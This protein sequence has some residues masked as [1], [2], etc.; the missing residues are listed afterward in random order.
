MMNDQNTYAIIGMFAIVITLYAMRD[1]H[2]HYL[3]DLFGLALAT[4]APRPLYAIGAVTLLAIIRHS[5]LAHGLAE[6]VP[7]W[8]LMV[9]LPGAR[10][11]SIS[12]EESSALESAYKARISGGNSNDEMD[13]IP[14]PVAEKPAKII[15][16]GESEVLARLVLAKKIGLT[17]AVQIGAGAKSGKR[18]Q[19]NT[20]LVRE[21]IER[22]K[23]H[24]PAGSNLKQFK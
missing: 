6:C 4:I 23:N 5:P 15:T 16:L 20:A 1:S 22:L 17:D 3:P 10:N 11:M 7:G 13:E 19:D 14:Q 8:L 2:T 12:E 24:Y 21:A 9:V 18:Y